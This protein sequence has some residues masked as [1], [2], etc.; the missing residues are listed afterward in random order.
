MI[1]EGY[2]IVLAMDANEGCYGKYGKFSPLKYSLD[3]PIVPSDHDGTLAT[4]ICS[5][6]L[7]DMKGGKI[8]LIIYSYLQICYMVP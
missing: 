7:V 3:S 6:G 4:L 5:C 8:A 1:K 2:S